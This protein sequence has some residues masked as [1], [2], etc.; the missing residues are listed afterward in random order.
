MSHTHLCHVPHLP[1]PS[2][3]HLCHVPLIHTLL[4]PASTSYV[5]HPPLP[6]TPTTHTPQ[7]LVLDSPGVLLLYF[8]RAGFSTDKAYHDGVLHYDFRSS[9]TDV[10]LLNLLKAC[11]LCAFWSF[12]WGK[13]FAFVT[14]IVALGFDMAKLAL[15]D[16]WESNYIH[17]GILVVSLAAAPIQVT[18]VAR[19]VYTYSDPDAVLAEQVE[20]EEH[21]GHK[22]DSWSAGVRRRRRRQRQARRPAALDMGEEEDGG[23]YHAPL[24]TQDEEEA[25][26][27]EPQSV[28]KR[29]R[30]ML[31]LLFRY[32]QPDYG[33]LL[34]GFFF[35]VLSS[36]FKLAIP[37]FASSLL[38]LIIEGATAQPPTATLHTAA[39]SEALFYF[40]LSVV[41]L[42]FFTCLRIWCTAKAEVRLVA[43]LQRILFFAIM[44]Q[45]IS[46]Y[47]VQGTGAL[48]SRLTSDCTLLGAIFTTNIN[49]V[50]QSGIN[51]FGSTAYL[52]VLD[53]RLAGAYLALVLAFMVLT[54]VFGAYAKRMQRQVQ[55]LK[56]DAN[57]LADQSIALV[58][59]VRAFA[60]ED[61]EKSRYDYRTLKN[62]EQELKVKMIWTV[63]VPLVTL[64]QNGLVLVVLL[65][66]GY[67]VTEQGLTARS[68]TAFYFYSTTITDAMQSLADNILS[69]L[70][71]L[72]A[73]EKIMDIIAQQ[74][75]IPVKGG[76]IPSPH[77]G[78]S[79]PADLLVFEDVSLVY[80]SEKHVRVPVIEHLHLRIR[81]G[82]RVAMVGLSGS[83]KSSLISMLLR[84][85]EPSAGRILYAGHD[86]SE[87][88]PRWVK[89]QLGVVMQDAALFNISLRE[90]IAYGLEDVDEAEVVR[91]A[92]MASIHAFILSLPEGYDTV[93]GERGV[94]LSGGERQR[95]GIARALLRKP[96]LLILDEATSALDTQ[97]EAYV[98]EALAKLHLAQPSLTLIT[99][100]HRLST[101]VDADRILVMAKG[102]IVE[103]GTHTELLEHDG[104]YAELVR[105]QLQEEIIHRKASV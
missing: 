78:S 89:A 44:R 23:G 10:V 74:P 55:T 73:G 11:I 28:P 54:R 100:A 33:L 86:L 9:V 104:V 35:I 34:A 91:C 32:A 37:N 17:L 77:A 16:A 5:S 72:G 71:G 69:I 83:G 24:L 30:S 76:L 42:S 51:L 46:F 103:D 27:P 75:T 38:T 81:Q 66:G 21:A 12:A 65:L 87:L 6:R 85:Y 50:V 99:I 62:V 64:I 1:A 79:L 48:T 41:G 67:L 59:L 58:R 45:D 8:Y 92:K 93:V 94:T 3:T 82:Q 57:A 19:T 90:N 39:F 88:D 68:L 40:V 102:K 15:Y 47:D 4:C 53:A 96:K 63:Y 80:A 43:R 22:K 29:R 61:W 20:R 52:F 7:S 2:H 101:V 60:S 36:L 84:Y 70:T 25:Q 14:P 97:T 13:P 98:Q 56:A 26:P 105:H 18:A 31:Y 49:L 95:V